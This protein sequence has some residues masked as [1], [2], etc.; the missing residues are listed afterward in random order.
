MIMYNL[1]SGMSQYCFENQN[2]QIEKKLLV[3]KITI[4]AV[5][6]D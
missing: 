6:E 5:T 3:K 4:A 1:S 2:F